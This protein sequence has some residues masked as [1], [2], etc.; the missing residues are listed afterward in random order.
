ME[1]VVSF[2]IQHEDSKQL[3]S[4]AEEYN[5]NTLGIIQIGF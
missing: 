4:S 2:D 1:A 3:A 5:Y